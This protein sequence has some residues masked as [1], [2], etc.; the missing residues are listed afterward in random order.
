MKNQEELTKELSSFQNIWTGGYR[1]GYNKK[2]NQIGIEE[3]LKASIKPTDTV[4]EIGCG[5]GQWTSL[6]SSLANKVFC[7]DAKTLEDNQLIN[8]LNYRNVGKN[9]SFF[10]AKN[11]SLSE[12]TDNSL[13]FVFSYDVFCHISLTGQ[14]EYLKNLYSKCK[15]GCRIL[16]MFA[17]PYKYAQN[18][19]EHI[20]LAFGKEALIDLEAAIIKSINDC[21]GPSIEG[22][23]YFV[24]MEN[25]VEICLKN[26]Y[27]ILN[28][29]LNIDK[30]NPM[31]L[32]T[33]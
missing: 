30:T 19:P 17:D 29:D 5:G 25:F 26:D 28:K 22:R 14:E 10:Q 13:D 3:Y 6:L 1:T 7:N 24:G 20:E 31:I 15:R 9:V 2:R 4:F 11:F 18:E 21:D 23:W 16:I 32:F 27:T 8:Y 12:L 33:K